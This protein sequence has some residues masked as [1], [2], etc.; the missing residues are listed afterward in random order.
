[1]QKPNMKTHQQR[2]LS[3]Y[4]SLPTELT[5]RKSCKEEKKLDKIRG[6]HSGPHPG[7]IF[8]ILWELRM[9]DTSGLYLWEI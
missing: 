9:T 2:A 8:G 4:P 5:R 6:L 3:P 7:F 1:M